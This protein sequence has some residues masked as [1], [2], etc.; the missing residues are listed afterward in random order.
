MRA[1]RAEPLA[2]ERRLILALLISLAATCWVV[3]VW[4][5]GILSG[6]PASAGMP[7]MD[8][9]ANMAG[10]PMPTPASGLS[11]TMGMGALLFLAMWVV[12]MV[13]MMFPTAAP[14]I[15]TFNRVYAG[16]RQQGQAFVPT[17]VFV[18]AYLIVW[19]LFGVLAY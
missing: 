17:W 10:A 18:G 13:T 5:P 1:S 9:S 15:L 4:Q 11:L 7:G 16:K 19:V 14:M 6:T 8:Q 3:L 2:R 12:M